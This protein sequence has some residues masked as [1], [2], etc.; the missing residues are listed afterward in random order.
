MIL[1]ILLM[2]SFSAWSSLWCHAGTRL[3]HLFEDN[4]GLMLLE[5]LMCL[6]YHCRLSHRHCFLVSFPPFW[7]ELFPCIPSFIQV[8]RTK[9]FSSVLIPCNWKE[10]KESNR[11]IASN[12]FSCGWYLSILHLYN[13]SSI[14]ETG[15]ARGC[16][17]QYRIKRESN[18][19]LSTSSLILNSAW[20]SIMQA[21]NQ[22]K[23]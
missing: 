16:G 12:F 14:L 18:E 20:T 2:I 17:W 5:G 11:T 22:G 21:G 15:T 6:Y 3:G 8:M 9:L 7:S 23:G 1:F 4:M 10:K 13:A 19:D